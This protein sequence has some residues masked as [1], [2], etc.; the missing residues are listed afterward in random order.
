MPKKVVEK[1]SK[2]IEKALVENF[3]SL[4]KVLTNLA[5]KFDNLSDRIS[6]LLDIF[7]ISAK[8]LAEKDFEKYKNTDNKE[9]M[10]KLDKLLE[11]NKTLAKG[12]TLLH[13]KETEPESVYK[14]HFNFEKRQPHF[15]QRTEND[16][17]F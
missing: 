2:S 10:E 9:V 11:Q 15:S 3:V 14:P 1:Q 17:Y 4:Q 12:L 8:A 13:E 5:L 6:K 16:G 7:E